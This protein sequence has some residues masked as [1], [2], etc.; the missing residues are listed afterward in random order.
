MTRR[1]ELDDRYTERVYAGVLGKLIGVYLG[2]PVEG[3]P[4]ESI[5]DRFGL[6]DRFVNADLG[7]PLIVADDDIS[8]SLAFGR[9]VEDAAGRPVG[10]AEAGD[11]W[12]NYIIED[13]TILWWGGFGRSTEHTAYLNLRAGIRAPRSGSSAQNGSTLAEQIGAQ[14]FSDAFALMHPGDPE[15][16]VELTRAAASVSH[17]GVA[18]DAAGFFAAMRAEAFATVDLDA[19]TAVGRSFVTDARLLDV[20]DAVSERVSADDDW[21]AVRDWVDERYGYARYPGPCHALS[22]TAMAL[23]ALRLG[24]DDFSRAVAVASSVGFDTDSNA[25]TVG[26]LNGVRLGLAGLDAAPHLRGPVADRAIVVSADGGEAVTDAAREARRIVGSA[27][28]LRGLTPPT[29]T[30]R[31]DFSLPG[32]VHGFTVCPHLSPTAAARSGGLRATPAEGLAVEVAAGETVAVST[33]TFLDP[34]EAMTDFSTIA[35]P[36]LYPGDEVRLRMT[37]VAGAVRVRP[38]VLFDDGTAVHREDGEPVVLEP[39]CAALDELRWTVPAHGNT[40]PFRLGVE[41]LADSGA[42]LQIREIDWTGAPAVF[43]QQGLLQTSIWDTTPAALAP[44]VSS[45]RNWEADFGSTYCVSHPGDGGVV[46]LGTRS[47]TDYTVSS[48]LTLSLHRTAGLVVRARGHR[49]YSAGVFTG[50]EVQLIDQ[51]DEIRTVLARAAFPDPGDTRTRVDLACLGDRL[52]LSVDGVEVLR[53]STGRTGG[54]GA[55]FL[56]ERG[57]FTADGF[58]VARLTDVIDDHDRKASE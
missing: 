54:G 50:G 3:W 53:A 32:A 28:S 15:G 44:W 46:T 17:D 14:I 31:F 55:G 58:T 40:L 11:T 35:S 7:V 34:L 1:I 33:P 9:V 12:L 43:E 25:G 10:A 29:P 23:A 39:G 51:R 8:G 4:Y 6:V 22:N 26:C 2:R 45:A 24:G 56:V 52:I 42:Q 47:W 13:R 30:A 38:Y 5:Q 48:V 21:R 41:A 16:A 57:T 18:L 37:A 49:R 20:I 27:H 36:T 19:L